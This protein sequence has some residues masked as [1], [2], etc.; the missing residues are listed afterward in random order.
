MKILLSSGH[1]Y[2][3]VQGGVASARVH[4]WL[5]KGLSEMGHRVLYFLPLGAAEP[6]PAGVELLDRPVVD[7]DVAHNHELAGRPWVRSCHVDLGAERHGAPANW[8]FVSRSL[9]NTYGSSRYVVNGIDPVHY[10][11]SDSKDMYVLHIASLSWGAAK[12]VETAISLAARLDFKLVVAGGGGDD[13][14][15]AHV[16]SLC[17][18]H[19]C[20]YVGNVLGRSKAEL[21][22]GARALLFPTRL[23]EGCPLVILEAL[24][25]GTPVICSNRGAC[26]ELVTP[27]V[28]FVCSS[29]DDYARA[30]REAGSIAPRTCRAK[31][32]RDFHYLRMTR[33]YLAEY[34]R[35][36]AAAGQP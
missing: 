6:L 36:I 9:A 8:I 4:D 7:V 13:R 10:L 14:F 28:G 16:E 32:M 22:A 17:K 2:P 33:D 31:A 23:N 5:A 29:D 21:F 19:G 35:E 34:E 15:T 27:E 12:G 3:G 24:M 11:Y 1:R 20:R 26:P 18:L 25:S 30:L